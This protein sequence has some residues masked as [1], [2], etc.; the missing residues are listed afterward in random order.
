AVT[1]DRS[2]FLGERSDIGTGTGVFGDSKKIATT[3]DSQGFHATD[4]ARPASLSAYDFGGSVN[5]LESFLQTG[6]LFES[7]RAIDADNVWTDG[8]VVDGHVYQ[9]WTYDYYFKQFGRHGMDDHDSP[10]SV[11]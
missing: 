8:A 2:S 4:H 6:S 11:I 7:D 5:R 3:R 9:G 10:I 1:R